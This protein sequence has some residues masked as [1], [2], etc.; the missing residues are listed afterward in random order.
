MRPRTDEKQVHNAQFSSWGGASIA[1][2]PHGLIG[3]IAPSFLGT[4]GLPCSPQVCPS[5]RSQQRATKVSRTLAPL[6]TNYFNVYLGVEINFW[7]PGVELEVG[8]LIIWLSLVPLDQVPTPEK[9]VGSPSH[10]STQMAGEH[11]KNG[12]L[13]MARPDYAGSGMVQS[14]QTRT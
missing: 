14:N 9:C 12:S 8:F 1:S 11:P 3:L 4:R 13:C 10:R 5:P 7:S 6:D 2:S